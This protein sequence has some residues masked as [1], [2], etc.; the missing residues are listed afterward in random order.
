MNWRVLVGAAATATLALALAGC[1]G[2]AGGSETDSDAAK[3]YDEINGLSGQE[4]TDRLVELA[5]AEG[6]L[7]IYH[8][9]TDLDAL[10]EAFEKAYDIDVAPTRAQS[11]TVLQKVMTEAESGNFDVDVIENPYKEN[12]FAEQQGVFYD[13]ESEYRDA[14]VEEARLE[15]WTA[16]YFNVFVVGWNSDAV[17]AEEIP[18]EIKDFADP[19]WKGRVS[20]EIGD[21]DWYAAVSQYY[22]GQGMSE[23]E[24]D[25]M[26][27]AIA[28][29]AS[30]EKG[31]S[32][33][34]DMLSAGKLQ[35][36]LSIYQHTV[37]GAAAETGAPVEWNSEGHHVGPVVISPTGAGV[38]RSAPHPAAAMLFLDF[39]LGEEGQELMAENFRVGSVPRED[40]PIAGV[41]TVPMP[42]EI[43]TEDYE[44]WDDKYRALV[45]G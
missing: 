24:V 12:I 16:N 35:V 6:E 36:A 39:M 43:A 7:T 1:G 38:V 13:Y 23:Q 45:G 34:G 32:T 9:N 2:T 41:E 3:V 25:E 17:D 11:E 31:H 33:M 21:V 27:A 14:V 19:K 37:D 40:S 18:E 8:S 5:E 20:L 4:R 29:H 44:F 30:V 10:I 42:L 28:A 15:G 26:W 22:L